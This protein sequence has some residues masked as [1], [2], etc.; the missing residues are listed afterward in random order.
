MHLSSYPLKNMRSI[1]I[2]GLTVFLCSCSYN[3]CSKSRDI[4]SQ[5]HVRLYDFPEIPQKAKLY[6]YPKNNGF[7]T[8][9][10]EEELKENPYIDVG[11]LGKEF[12]G[13]SFSHDF[14][15]NRDYRIVI[16]DTI[17]FDINDLVYDVLVDST[18]MSATGFF[19]SSCCIFGMK[20]NDKPLDEE[21]LFTNYFQLPYSMRKIVHQK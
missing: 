3:P 15:K 19:L 17:F 1:V 10:I 4:S 7:M 18:R 2:L 20:V 8:P 16:N 9:E 6:V 5:V 21:F 11:H 13:F 14:I 12:I